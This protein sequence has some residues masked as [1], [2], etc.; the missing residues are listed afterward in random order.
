[1]SSNT[2]K[3]SESGSSSG[4]TRIV[5]VPKKARSVRKRS[6]LHSTERDAGL[7]VPPGPVPDYVASME[8]DST[9]ANNICVDFLSTMDNFDATPPPLH[10]NKPAT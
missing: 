9:T 8:I 7:A 5:D 4:K 2:K 3:S 10:K 6:D 1:M